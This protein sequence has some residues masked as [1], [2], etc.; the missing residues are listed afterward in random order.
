MRNGERNQEILG[1]SSHRGDVAEVRHSCPKTDVGEG[2]RREIEMHSFNQEIGRQE[3]SAVPGWGDHRS[4][5]T[6]PA[7]DHRTVCM[8]ALLQSTDKVE[9]TNCRD[10]LGPGRRCHANEMV[11]RSEM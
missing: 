5:V 11:E 2:G 3:L 8:I 9:L 4:I 6:D 10:G 1:C 7:H